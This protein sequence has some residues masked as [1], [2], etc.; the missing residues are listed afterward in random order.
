VAG[1]QTTGGSGD[2]QG[3]LISFPRSKWVPDDGIEPLNTGNGDELA[4]EGDS[5]VAD[6][7]DES[8]VQSSRSPA[9]EATDFWASGDTQ[10]FVGVAPSPH[11]SPPTESAE[12]APEP[13]GRTARRARRS[14]PLVRRMPRTQLASSLVAVMLLAAGGA[15]AWQL[16]GGNPR[17][18]KSPTIARTSSS[19]Y[20]SESSS[21]STDS[22]AVAA[23]H[24]RRPVVLPHISARQNKSARRV[25]PIHRAIT[26]VRTESVSYHAPAA[27]STASNVTT[28]SAP[29]TY[30]APPQAG[31][32]SPPQS[33]SATTASASR[34]SGSGSTGQPAQPGPNGA[35]TCVSNCG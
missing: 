32:A 27:T 4:G 12:S 34:G 20:A 35:L 11:G 13:G 6:G 2:E 5:A 29:L 21:A 16:L 33:S 22:Y 3:T 18:S 31:L 30:E 8:V 19:T 10:E 7:V 24:L 9:I 15:A 25:K 28:S 14:V 26:P 1:S 23:A 17:G